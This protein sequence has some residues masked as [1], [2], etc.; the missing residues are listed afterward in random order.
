MMLSS[1]TAC[2]EIV[3]VK[4]SPVISTTCPAMLFVLL[5]LLL[6]VRLLLVN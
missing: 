5:L 1:L 3:A 6:M 4:C 2:L